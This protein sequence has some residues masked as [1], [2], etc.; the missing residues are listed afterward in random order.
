MCNFTEEHLGLE[1]PQGK[2]EFQRIHR[3]EKLN[4]GKTRSIIARF[5]RYSDKESVVEK[6]R[7]KL[8]GKDFYISDYI[9]KPL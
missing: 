7:Q 6:A 2:I 4:P 1:N 9:P 5:L 3:L 8:K